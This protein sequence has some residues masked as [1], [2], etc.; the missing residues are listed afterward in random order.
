MDAHRRVLIALAFA[1]AAASA[2]CTADEGDDFVDVCPGACLSMEGV[3]TM[4]GSC[5]PTYCTILQDDC[6]LQLSCDDGTTATA[7]I[8]AG[9]VEYASVRGTTCSATM[10]PDGFS[11]QCSGTDFQCSFQAS[12]P[13]PRACIGSEKIPEADPPAVGDCTQAEL[14]AGLAGCDCHRA[15]RFGRT[16]LFCPQSATWAEAQAAC[17]GRGGDLVTIDDGDEQA[18]VA[19][20][21]TR[22]GL[23]APWVGANDLGFEGT[24]TW[25]DGS[26]WQG[27]PWAE[28]E[29]N[30]ELDASGTG[31]DCVHLSQPLVFN[32]LECEAYQSFICEGAGTLDR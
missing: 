24:F 16:Y 14:D 11:G 8:E 28:G 4:S 18:Y 17:R 1:V 23:S 19:A 30:N 15:T 29:P 6:S 3:Y 31:E 26:P 32:D 5:P 9:R 2:G 20:L 27:I 7:R 21:S 10:A 25:S 12:R 13:L 22:L